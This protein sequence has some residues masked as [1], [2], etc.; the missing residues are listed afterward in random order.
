MRS[1]SLSLFA[2]AVLQPGLAL[3]EAPVALDPITIDGGFF[4]IEQARYGRAFSVISSQDIQKRG[5]TSV[6]DA[7][8]AVPGVSINGSGRSFTQIRIRGG[9][10]GHTL[11]LVDGVEIVGGGDDYALS[12]LETADIERIEVLRGPQSVYFGSNA[13]SG[14][15]NIITKKAGQTGYGG[16]IEAGR[17]HIA[18]L[19]TATAG[20]RG[21]L[22]LSYTD[23]YDE[24]VDESGDKGERDFIDRESLRLNGEW[25]ATNQLRLTASASM[26]REQYAYDDQPYFGATDVASSVVD[27]DSLFGWRRESM[28]SFG[29]QYE[30]AGGRVLH[31]L[32]L[33]ETVNKQRYAET[34]DWT[35]GTTRDY[36]YR[37]KIGLDGTASEA[38]HSLSALLQ[39]QED[40]HSAASTYHREM[41]SYALDYQGTL[42]NGLNLQA[43]LRYDD[44]KVFEDFL[45]W[46]LSASYD[47]NSQWRLHG[48]AGRASVNPTYYKLYADDPW[49]LGNPNL[50]PEQNRSIDAGVAFTAADE[51]W[52]ADVTAFYEVLDAEIVWDPTAR[53][54]SGRGSYVNETGKSRRKGIEVS[55][56]WQAH[57][58][59][60]F[61]V[62]Y[63]Y[64]RATNPDHALETRRPKHELGLQATWQSADERLAV[65][66][67]L[68]HVA[69]NFD[70]Q[71]FNDNAVLKLKDYS[72]VNLSASYKLT[73]AVNLTGRVLNV[74]DTDYSDTWGYRAQDRAVW[75]GLNASF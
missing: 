43:G 44:N 57:R 52:R 13:S 66:A 32:S 29:A 74:F 56:Q 7:L 40:Q 64:L 47:L 1:S 9:E 69:G 41:T 26:A 60:S 5:Y 48:S 22:R 72:V 16:S 11:V 23:S 71:F 53:D 2:L 54:G 35:K 14:V 24:G 73:E 33:S 20:A 49:T 4:S 65:T 21:G 18:N 25:R 30:S 63:T 15:V 39:H 34:E 19:W 28:V 70:I 3:A 42:D 58:Q 27:D 17:G 31:D 46:T 75:L 67:D 12:G 61:G 36:K 6:Q 68:R 62:N 45:G 51:A 38:K 10:V 59:L 50:A 55:G 8:R 37:A